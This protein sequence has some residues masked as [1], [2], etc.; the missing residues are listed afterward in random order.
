[1]V[2][3]TELLFDHCFLRIKNKTLTNTHFP[4]S[5]VNRQVIC[6]CKYENLVFV[7]PIYAFCR[8]SDPH[9]GI[10]SHSALLLF[11]SS[12]EQFSRDARYYH[13]C[14]QESNR[15]DPTQHGVREANTG[16]S[17]VRITAMFSVN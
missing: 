5:I 9:I 1:M 14:V 4:Y 6:G 17:L 10:L 2:S 3:E 7:V 13:R 8:Y 12:R 16:K 15:L 11:L